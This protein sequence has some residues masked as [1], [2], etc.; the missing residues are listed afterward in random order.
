M[1]P[2]SAILCLLK[3]AQFMAY[4]QEFEKAIEIYEKIGCTDNSLLGF[5]I[6]YI[7]DLFFKAGL[8]HLCTGVIF[9]DIDSMISGFSL[10]KKSTCKIRKN[11]PKVFFSK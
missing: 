6:A 9:I 5:G 8:C 2:S 11:R 1:F 10:C 3:V 4:S 7:K